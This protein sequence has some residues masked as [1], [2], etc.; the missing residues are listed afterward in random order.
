MKDFD[1]PHVLRLLGIS[2]SK[3][4]TPWVVLPY[5]AQGDLRSYVADPRRVI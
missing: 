5:M 2:I 3:S 4:A 1:H